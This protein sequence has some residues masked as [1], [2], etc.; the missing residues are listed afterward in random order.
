M[1][2][3][4]TN[5]YYH[6]PSV[7]EA[8]SALLYC[9]GGNLLAVFTGSVEQCANSSAGYQLVLC[10]RPSKRVS[11]A[12]DKLIDYD[13]SIDNNQRSD[14]RLEMSG[15]GEDRSRTSASVFGR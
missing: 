14:V 15:K 9:R 8:V 6:A 11:S 12:Q 3:A 13:Q 7:R 1:P 2:P 4:A 5:S 10:L